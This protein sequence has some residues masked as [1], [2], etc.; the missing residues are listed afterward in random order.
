[1]IFNS[2]PNTVPILERFLVLEDTVLRHLTLELQDKL[3][4]FRIK[5]A[6]ADNRPAEP[7]PEKAPDAKI[8]ENSETIQPEEKQDMAPVIDDAQETAAEIAVE[9]TSNKVEE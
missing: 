4:Q 5:R 3:R 7:V 8:E 6:M 1:M 9:A 2:T